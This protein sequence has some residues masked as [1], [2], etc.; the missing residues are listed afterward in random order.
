[1]WAV[2]MPVSIYQEVMRFKSIQ[3][4]RSKSS[5][6]RRAPF[7]NYL[8][9]QPDQVFGC[10]NTWNGL[11]FSSI[12][13][14]LQLE[15][16]SKRNS[17]RF[18]VVGPFIH[19]LLR[20]VRDIYVLSDLSPELGMRAHAYLFFDDS[21]REVSWLEAGGKDEPIRVVHSPS[22]GNVKGCIS[23]DCGVKFVYSLF[24]CF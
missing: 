15:M 10:L 12:Q 16:I 24:L 17:Y 4:L 3:D 23:L 6:F 20:Y 9:D 5:S 14:E 13:D 18:S 1:M 19:D 11:Y 2:Y 7:V 22:V 21:G 8:S